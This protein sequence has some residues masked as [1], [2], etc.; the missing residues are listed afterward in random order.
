MPE[1]A[2]NDCPVKIPGELACVRD[3]IAEI[4]V[5]A[6]ATATACA[7]RR[8]AQSEQVQA[9]LREELERKRY[10][11]LTGL[12]TYETFKEKLE[13]GFAHQRG[14]DV[15]LVDTPE[16]TVARRPGGFIFIDGE[17]TH[18]LNHLTSHEAVDRGLCGLAQV[19]KSSIR[20][21]DLCCRRSGDEFIVFIRGSADE[22]ESIVK[23]LQKVLYIGA[24]FK[25]NDEEYPLV[26]GLHVEHAEDITTYEQALQMIGTADAKLGEQKRQRDASNAGGA[27][28][29]RIIE[30]P[31]PE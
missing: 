19:L 8:M 22:F 5:A 14:S 23:R 10:D 11:E 26:A 27:I 18:E 4:G 28:V 25:Y 3:D 21:G 24:S 31:S 9:E 15:R 16:G 2:C 7:F 13:R 12:L 30:M 20:D 17:H 29:R 6:Q 1:L